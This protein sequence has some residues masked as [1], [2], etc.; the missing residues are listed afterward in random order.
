MGSRLLR[1]TSFFSENPTAL[2][3][4]SSKIPNYFPKNSGKSTGSRQLRSTTSK[5]FPENP[6]SRDIFQKKFQNLKFT[7]FSKVFLSKINFIV[8]GGGTLLEGVV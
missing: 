2:R 1:P 8:V 7:F 5:Y 3:A 4:T 6:Q